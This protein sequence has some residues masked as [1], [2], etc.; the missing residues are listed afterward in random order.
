[1]ADAYA[2]VIRKIGLSS[3]SAGP[4][5]TNALTGLTEAVKGRTP[6]VLLCGDTPLAALAAFAESIGQAAQ[7][8][9]MIRVSVAQDDCLQ[10]AR[11]DLERVE[12]VQESALAHAR[13]KQDAGLLFAATHIDEDR[14]AVLGNRWAARRVG[15]TSAA[16]DAWRRR[17]PA[18]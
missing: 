12:V 15:A 3:V 10:V 8:G 7:T 13:V 2:R 5:F 6:L 9:R 17:R 18:T 1:M 4:G 16:A 14:E 11:R